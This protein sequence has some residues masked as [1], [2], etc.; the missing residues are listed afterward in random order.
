MSC[1]SRTCA[2]IQTTRDLN[3]KRRDGGVYRVHHSCS[4]GR[5]E[6]GHEEG[7]HKA[8]I[9]EPDEVEDNIKKDAAK[10]RLL[11]LKCSEYNCRSVRM[12]KSGTRTVH[13][14]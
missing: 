12:L 3:I 13:L 7:L 2:R 9:E 4:I 8:K 10:F 1:S 14:I 5:I 11:K 6:S